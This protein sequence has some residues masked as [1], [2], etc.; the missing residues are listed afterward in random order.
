MAAARLRVEQDGRD[1]DWD[2]VA[3]D[4]R[5]ALDGRLALEARLAERSRVVRRRVSATV[6]AA[7]PSVR[8]DN[9]ASETWTVVEVRAP[10]RPGLLYRVTRAMAELDLDLGL[11]KVATMGAEV[12][13]SFYVR[14]GRGTKVVDRDHQREVQR[15]VL[16]ALSV[17]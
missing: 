5:R 13:D 7:P 11:A 1:V 16:H 2:A 12:I 6:L 8:L 14:T 9:A 17:V 4:V 10:D 3:V 15:A